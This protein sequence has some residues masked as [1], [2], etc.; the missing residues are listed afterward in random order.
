[1][2]ISMHKKL[3]NFQTISCQRVETTALK[4]VLH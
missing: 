2:K 4:C 1:M 3:R